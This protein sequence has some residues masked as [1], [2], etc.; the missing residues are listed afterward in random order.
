[1]DP[2]SRS[3][4]LPF[5]EPAEVRLP[6]RGELLRDYSFISR[7]GAP[8]MLSD[9]RGKSNLVLILIPGSIDSPQTQLLH[10]LAEKSQQV[11]EDETR[12]IVVTRPEH[13]RTVVNLGGDFEFL[14]DSS[15]QVLLELGATDHPAIYITDKFREVSHIFRGPTLPTVSDI[16]GW[17]E[18]VATQCPECHPPEWPAVG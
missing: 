11:R 13:L 16:I 1:M 5:Q 6:S 9:F 2:I 12:L 17:I 4:V 8:V 15:G 18:F 10:S 14:S 3:R 7:D